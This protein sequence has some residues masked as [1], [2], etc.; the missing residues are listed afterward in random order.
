MVQSASRQGCQPRAFAPCVVN[1]FSSIGWHPC[2]DAP[3]MSMPSPRMAGGVAALNQPAKRCDPRGIRD[4]PLR[5]P[6]RGDRRH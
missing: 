2:R 6:M 4:S 1:A 5:N 3:L